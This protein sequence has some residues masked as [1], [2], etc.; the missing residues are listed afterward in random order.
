MDA[1]RERLSQRAYNSGRPA[2]A[3][4]SRG[5]ELTAEETALAA[6]LMEIYAS[7]EHDFA[8][9]AAELARRE[10]IAPKSGRADWSEALLAEELA[11]INADLDAAYEAHGYGA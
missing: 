2:L 5:R 1:F 6:A 7:G 10:V 4:Q 8:A 11:A 3:H 9:V